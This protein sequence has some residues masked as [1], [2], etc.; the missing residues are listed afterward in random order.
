MYDSVQ[1]IA[2][3]PSCHPKLSSFLSDS[4]LEVVVTGSR[5]LPRVTL[6]NF[7]KIFRNISDTHC[8]KT[9]CNVTYYVHKP[10]QTTTVSQSQPHSCFCQHDS[11][12][13]LTMDLLSTDF[14]M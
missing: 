4:L 12:G 14:S 7:W 10:Y 9:K 11:K 8:N 13:H 2:T 5:E 6:W 3:N 1:V